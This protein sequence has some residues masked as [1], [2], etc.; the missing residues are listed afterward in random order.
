MRFQPPL[1]P[2]HVWNARPRTHLQVLGGRGQA[3]GALLVA[4]AQR[5]SHDLSDAGQRGLGRL[6]VQERKAGAAGHK[7]L[8]GQAVLMLR[9]EVQESREGGT[10]T[11]MLRCDTTKVAAGPHLQESAAALHMQEAEL[12]LH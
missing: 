10:D 9:T 5:G 11:H 3:R 1:T 2:G 4:P 6:D 8:D 12:V 7:V